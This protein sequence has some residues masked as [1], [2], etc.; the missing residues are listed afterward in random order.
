[1]QD[2]KEWVMTKTGVAEISLYKTDKIKELDKNYYKLLSKIEDDIAEEIESTVSVIQENLIQ[3]AFVAGLAEGRKIATL[4]NKD[5]EQ[6]MIE[7]M[8]EENSQ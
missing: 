7:Y 3:G 2:F 5:I 6:I 4:L 1:M 8:K